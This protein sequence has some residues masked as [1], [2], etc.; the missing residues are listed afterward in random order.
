MDKTVRRKYCKINGCKNKDGTM[1]QG[2][3]FFRYFFLLF[4][5]IQTK[6]FVL[7]VRIP[8]SGEKRRKWIEAISKHQLFENIT[9]YTI[10]SLHF[11]EADIIRTSSKAVLKEDAIPINFHEAVVEPMQVDAPANI[12]R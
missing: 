1:D 12:M 4:Y 5:T 3:S 9:Y 7:N 11:N 10:C 8:L 6:M 2:V